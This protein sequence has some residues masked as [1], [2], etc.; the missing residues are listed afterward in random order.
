MKRAKGVE[1]TGITTTFFCHDGE[2][3]YLF[4]KRSENCRDEHGRWDCGGGGLEF[5]DRVLESLAKK[6][7]EEYGSDILEHEFLGYRDV[8]RE[9][10]GVKTHW[11]SLDFK[12]LLDRKQVKNMEPHKFT[13][14]AWFR[15][16]SLPSL[17][18]MHS[19][20]GAALDKYPGLFSE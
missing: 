18:E 8:H 17:E 7:K 19:Q 2:G 16:E 14:I 3:N 5:G 1:Y 15:K 6:V 4:A 11:I 12:V 10:V 13:E 9:H 20:F